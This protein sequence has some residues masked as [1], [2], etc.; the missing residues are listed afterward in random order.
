MDIVKN[1]TK[2]E[3]WFYYQLSYSD[4]SECFEQFFF[5]DFWKFRYY[6]NESFFKKLK[7]EYDYDSITLVEVHIQSEDNKFHIHMTEDTFKGCCHNE[8]DDSLI[9]K[10]YINQIDI[11]KNRVKSATEILNTI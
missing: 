2:L 8:V 4:G 3:G 1:F 5:K 9:D 6:S 11:M 10:N 7:E